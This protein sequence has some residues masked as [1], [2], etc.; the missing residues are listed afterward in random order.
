M[1]S[2]ALFQSQQILLLHHLQ[3]LYFFAVSRFALFLTSFNAFCSICTVLF[4]VLELKLF[5]MPGIQIIGDIW[6]NFFHISH[7]FAIVTNSSNR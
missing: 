6:I 7:L 5:E 3:F 2:Q 1:E 4:E